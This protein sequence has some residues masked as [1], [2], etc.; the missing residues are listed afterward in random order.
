MSK[1]HLKV[2]DYK[3]GRVYAEYSAEEKT[4]TGWLKESDL[5]PIEPPA[6]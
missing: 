3:P 5:F 1:F 4:T 2:F 6:Q